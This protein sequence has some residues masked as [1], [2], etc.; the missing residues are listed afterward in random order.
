MKTV[1]SNNSPISMKNH[2]AYVESIKTKRAE[3]V[4]AYVENKL[5]DTELDTILARG[6]R[7]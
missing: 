1:K 5:T 4:R 6:V 7:I 2:T 3:V